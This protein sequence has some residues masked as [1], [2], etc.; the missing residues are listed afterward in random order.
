M[1]AG[2]NFFVNSWCGPTTCQVPSRCARKH[3]TVPSKLKAGSSSYPFRLLATGAFGGEDALRAPSSGQFSG[4]SSG[5]IG[6]GHSQKKMGGAGSPPTPFLFVS[7][8]RLSA[9]LSFVPALSVNVQRLPARPPCRALRSERSERRRQPFCY[10]ALST[11]SHI[12]P[13]LPFQRSTGLEVVSVQRDQTDRASVTYH[14]TTRA[15]RE[16]HSRILRHQERSL[17]G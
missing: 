13:L 11:T 3:P 14:Y 16:C 2:G 10:T 6:R 8:P 7:C 15:P 4:A 9:T 12:D 5:G 1:S 17:R